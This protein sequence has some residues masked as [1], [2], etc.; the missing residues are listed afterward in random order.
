MVSIRLY[1]WW[2]AIF[3]SIIARLIALVYYLSGHHT[4]FWYVGVQSEVGGLYMCTYVHSSR[5]GG[6]LGKC[7]MRCV[8]M[9][10]CSI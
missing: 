10:T 4:A 8:C 9:Y 6:C 7:G 2:C 3:Y 1:N 5:F